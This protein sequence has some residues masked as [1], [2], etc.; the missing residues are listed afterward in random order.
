MRANRRRS[1]TRDRAT[2]PALEGLEDR[3]LLSA[4]LAAQRISTATWQQKFE[5]AAAVWEAVSNIHLAR[6]SDDGSAFGTAGNQ[7]DD[8]R[9]GDIR[10]GGDSTLNMGVLGGTFLPPPYN[11]G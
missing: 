8:A 10:I 3:F 11:G 5:Q 1:P 7:Q 4:A 6:V 2:R 9:F